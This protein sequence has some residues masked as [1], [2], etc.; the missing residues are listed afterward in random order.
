MYIN[1]FH[2]CRIFLNHE[3]TKDQES[4]KLLKKRILLL[5]L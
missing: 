1:M 2:N 4:K 5:K 3:I